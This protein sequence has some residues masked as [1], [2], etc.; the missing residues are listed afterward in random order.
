MRFLDHQAQASLS[1]LRPGAVIVALVAAFITAGV[2]VHAGVGRSQPERIT[3]EIQAQT[4][5]AQPGTPATPD[6]SPAVLRAVEAAFLT[7]DERRDLRLR[8]GLWTED[9]LARAEDRAAAALTVGA[10]R[11]IDTDDN[12]I[13]AVIR[14]DAALRLGDP[15]R[16]IA[17]L[18]NDASPAA[19]RITAHALD[20]LGRPGDAIAT[21]SSLAARLS[22]SPLRDA[23]AVAEAVRTLALR[24]RLAGPLVQGAR[25]DARLLAMLK[26]A[27][28]DLD[29]LSW[30][31][32][33]VE[34]ELLFERHNLAEAAAAAQEALRLNPRAASAARVLGL[35]SVESFNVEGTEAIAANLA[36]LA[37]DFG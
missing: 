4:G 24:R 35:V 12:R 2:P 34:A 27:R 3:R 32:R 30:K 33:V 28:E 7:D 19:I 18:A 23:D 11:A 8:H 26:T 5:E 25:D 9:D 1:K 29:P 13:P 15:D 17:L 31:V 36:S 21:A 37:E 16:A 20:V 10:E 14:A 22:G 6:V